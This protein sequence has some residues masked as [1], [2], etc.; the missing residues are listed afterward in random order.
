M[1]VMINEQDFN[2]LEEKYYMQTN[3]INQLKKDN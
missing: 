2:S 1:A 3:H